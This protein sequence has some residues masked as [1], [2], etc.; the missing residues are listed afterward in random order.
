MRIVLLTLLLWVM[1]FA[2]IENLSLNEALKILK[3]NNS[4]IKIAKLQERMAAFDT[5]IAQSYNYGSLNLIFN[6]L[7]SNDAGNVFGFKLQSRE[8]TFRDF[9]FKDFLG[10]VSYVLQ[11]S[12]DFDTFKAYMTNPQMQNQ[13]LSTA[14]HDLNYPKARNH[15]QTKLQYQVPLFT[16]FKL[17]MYEKISKSM[18]KMKQLEAKKVINE[19]IF[20]TKKTFSDIT[21][22]ENYIKN[23]EVLKSNMDKLENIIKT[24]KQVGYAKETDVLEVEAKKA[25]VLSYLNQAKLNRDLAYQYLSFLLNEDV[26]SIQHVQEVLPLPKEPTQKLVEKTVDIKRVKLGKKITQMNIKLQKSGFYPM[27]GAFGEYGSSDDK[28]FNDFFDKDAYTIGA[29]LKWNLFSGGKTSDEVQKAKLQ[30]MKMNE[31]EILAKRGL[32][33]KINQIKTE[34]VSKDFDIKAQS[35]E[36]ELSK[37]I[38]EMYVERYKVGLSNITDVLIKH[39]QEIK[40]LLKLLKTKTLRNEKVLELESLL[41]KETR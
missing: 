9:G 32:A 15:F 18:E 37:K 39:S 31:Q 40:A 3:K 4:N 11:N 41:D 5:K 25:E 33:L 28:P 24:F 21:L 20:Q 6:A 14:P 17:S 22:V 38:Y 23:L 19:M 10:G 36:F 26:G 7:R 27:I 12:P 8:A 16:G 1:A 30:Y 2:K 13:L 29:Q 35:K 34:V